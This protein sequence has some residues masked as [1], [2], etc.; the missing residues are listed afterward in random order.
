MPQI[1]FGLCPHCGVRVMRRGRSVLN[2]TGTPLNHHLSCTARD[3]P[4][5]DVTQERRP[6]QIA[7][8][9][10]KGETA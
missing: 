2:I 4:L 3:E 10:I 1:R 5:P 8:P 6:G 7:P 9:D